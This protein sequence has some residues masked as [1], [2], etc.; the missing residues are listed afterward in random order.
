MDLGTAVAAR[1]RAAPRPRDHPTRAPA[2]GVSGTTAGAPGVSPPPRPRPPPPSLTPGRTSTGTRL[3]PPDLP[4]A[5]AVR[6]GGGLCQRLHAGVHDLSPPAAGGA[7]ISSCLWPQL[8]AGLCGSLPLP[9]GRS[10]GGVSPRARQRPG[11]RGPSATAAADESAAGRRGRRPLPTGAQL[12]AGVCWPAR[13]AIGGVE[14]G[15]APDETRRG[16]LPVSA[17]GGGCGR[18]RAACPAAAGRLVI[19]C[20]FRCRRAVWAPRRAG[21]GPGGRK[22][23]R[24]GSAMP[25]GESGGGRQQS[26]PVLVRSCGTTLRSSPRRHPAAGEGCGLLFFAAADGGC[27]H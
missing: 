4:A 5:T 7:L 19:S 10:D 23:G 22:A 6:S 14:G 1:T 26:V 17:A 24:S 20:R 15:G 25:V 9:A 3:R 13:S 11:V 18:R 16:S 2:T 8:R 27:G 21:G 12:G